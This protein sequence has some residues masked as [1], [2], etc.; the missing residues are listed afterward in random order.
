MTN[1]T[2]KVRRQRYNQETRSRDEQSPYLRHAR[3]NV[4]DQNSFMRVIT[5]MTIIAAGL[6]LSIFILADNENFLE[7]HFG[8]NSPVTKLF[9]KLAATK[10]HKEKADFAFPFGLRR[11][12]IL[13]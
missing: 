5:I 13:F 1:Y 10:D 6:I 3:K 12:N 7:K 4:E 2:Q 8:E 9:M 11:Q